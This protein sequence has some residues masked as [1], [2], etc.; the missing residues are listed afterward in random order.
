MQL[1]S[2]YV[3]K[4]FRS[5][6]KFADFIILQKINWTKK[7]MI[8]MPQRLGCEIYEDLDSEGEEEEKKE[9]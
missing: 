9:E 8:M 6:E 2:H 3:E 5:V 1:S 7:L 4:I